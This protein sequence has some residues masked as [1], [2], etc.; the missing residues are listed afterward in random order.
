MNLK[1][2][3]FCKLATGEMQGKVVYEDDLL[4]AFHDIMPQAPVHILV[5]PKA[6]INS[7]SD[8]D[9]SNE[10]L[11]LNMLRIAKKLALENGLDQ[12]GYRLVI[13]TGNDG[14]QS[15]MHLHLHI[16]G[17]RSLGWPPG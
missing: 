6:H 12:T 17:G 2:C 5:I 9:E 13:N 10:A 8:I 1:N 7:F 14:G 16:L 3:I 15:V 11:M 4:L